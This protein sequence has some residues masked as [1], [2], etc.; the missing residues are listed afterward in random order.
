MDEGER[1]LARMND[2]LKTWEA[3]RDRRLVFLTCYRMMTENITA[4]VEARDFEDPEWV[5]TLM[6]NFADL[7]FR[8]LDAYESGQADSP[9]VWQIAFKAASNPHTHVLQDLVLGVNA[10]INYD[11]VFALSDL[12]ASEWQQLSPEQRQMR[13][14]DHRHVNDVISKTV[15]AVQDQ[16]IDR[17]EPLFGVMD[18]LLGPIDEWMT[19]WLISDW[20]EEVWEHA[21]RMLDQADETERQAILR[22]VE[23]ISIGRAKDILGKGGVSGLLEFI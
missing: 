4:A 3:T 10:H 17:F 22:H 9:P 8:A 20:R 6:I 2:L 18:K 16:V 21:T 14:R 5:N 1:V 19:S 7:Y 23:E 15:D 11:L 13:Y 12:L